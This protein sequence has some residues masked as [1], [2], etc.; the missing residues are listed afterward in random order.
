VTIEE[1]AP[2]LW[3]WRAWHPEWKQEVSSYALVTGDAFVL[4][5]PLVSGD[6]SAA[7]WAALDGDVR[8][9]G[10]P[11]ILI[12]VHFHTRSSREILDRYESSTLWAHEPALT[13][14]RRRIGETKSFKEGDVLP[15]GVEAIAM[16]HMDEAAFWLPSHETLLL[17]DSMVGKDGRAELSP[18]SWL[19]KR[20]TVDEQRVSVQRALERAPKRLLL[21]HG[22]PT[23]PAALEL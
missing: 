19:R 16:H 17:G 7:L 10:P 12:T 15:G 9:H 14:V 4:F 1:I 13:K 23:D 3:W 8:H 22:G 21:S 20:E 5:D 6:E 18:R 11:A 2:R